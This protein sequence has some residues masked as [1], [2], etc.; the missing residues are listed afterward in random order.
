MSPRTGRSLWQCGLVS[1]VWP[2]HDV[3]LVDDDVG[4]AKLTAWVEGAGFPC[5][6][7][8]IVKVN[9]S[10]RKENRTNSRH[11]LRQSSFVK[12]DRAI[13]LSGFGNVVGL[14]RR[15]LWFLLGPVALN[16]SS[17]QVSGLRCKWI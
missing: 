4:Q 14:S 17:E 5:S 10:S 13:G 6:V 9:G 15:S 3:D 2:W 8:S 12:L 1:A 11:Y 7:W 16:N